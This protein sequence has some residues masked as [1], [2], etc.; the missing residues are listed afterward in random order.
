MTSNS[1][2]YPKKMFDKALK[3]YKGNVYAP[4]VPV[5]LSPNFVHLVKNQAQFDELFGK[6]EEKNVET[7]PIKI[8][9]KKIGYDV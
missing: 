3:H 1:R 6:L 2:I 9:M 5:R 8:L 4:Y 7:D